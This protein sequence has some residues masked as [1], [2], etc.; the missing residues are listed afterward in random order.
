MST[1]PDTKQ[2]GCCGG[3]AKPVPQEAQQP[4]TKATT[5]DVKAQESVTPPQKPTTPQPKKSCCG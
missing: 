4:A 5:P 1:T 3:S 2:S